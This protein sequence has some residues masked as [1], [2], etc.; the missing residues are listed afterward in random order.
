MR[1]NLNWIK[2]SVILVFILGSLISQA[3]QVFQPSI[4]AGISATQMSGDGLGGWNKI[5]GMLGANVHLA[6]KTN[7]SASLGIQ[8]IQKGSRAKLDS[9]TNSS[10]AF[11]L[12]YF[13]VPICATYHWKKI[14][15]NIGIT[16]GALVYQKLMSNGYDYEIDPPFLAYEIGGISGLEYQLN[17]RFS[18]LAR[19]G[20]SFLPVREAPSAE[21]YSRY[22]QK[23]NF[24]QSLQFVLMYNFSLQGLMRGEKKE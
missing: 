17:D 22:Y 14:K 23:G 9:I 21:F 15:F 19:I 4:Y 18:V 16:A 10:Y 8:Y 3:Q 11:H 2:N 6:S 12:N 7:W 5:G 20:A 24:N 1:V 13:E